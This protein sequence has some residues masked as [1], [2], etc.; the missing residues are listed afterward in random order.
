MFEPMNSKVILCFLSLTLLSSTAPAREDSRIRADLQRTGTDPDAV[1]KVHWDLKDSR[2]KLDAHL[3]GLTPGVTYDFKVGGIIEGQFI[4]NP[5]GRAKLSFAQPARG[6]ALPLDFDPRGK[7]VSVSAGTNTVLQAI[8]SGTNEPPNISVA[9]E[10]QLT[11]SPVAGAGKA[12]ARYRNRA[13]K[14]DF[15][16]ELERVPAGSV[17]ELFVAGVKKANLTADAKG[18]AKVEFDSNPR[19]GK[20]LLDFDPRGQ[21]IEVFRSGEI[22]F[23]G[24]LLAQSPGIT[25]CVAGEVEKTLTSTGL[26]PDGKATARFRVRDDCRRE[27]KVEVE[28]VPVGAYALVVGG[29]ERATV[30]VASNGLA[31]KGEVEFSTDPDE[32]GKLLLD[33]EPRGLP[34]EI[35]QGTNLF[36]HG[37]LG[38]G[39]SNTICAPAIVEVPML[40]PGVEARAKGKARLRVRDN[41]REDFRVEVENLPLGNYNL[42]VGGTVRG[43]FGVVNRLGENEGEIEFKTNPDAPGDLL[44]DFNPRG[45]LIEVERGGTVYLN[46]VFPTP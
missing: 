32:V 46:R 20:L 45:Q 3:G 5:G 14:K 12:K 31:I 23:S 44:L 24:P 36:F 4:P 41:C 38:A 6:K 35:R 27:F 9:E 7:L 10:T 17:F 42:R 39:A 8:F 16:V 15:K 2:V 29:I 37:T 30:T 1:A 26:D 34:I 21:L 18:R 43:I 13:G 19:P 25:D 33:F 40:N 11:P 22:W 28:D